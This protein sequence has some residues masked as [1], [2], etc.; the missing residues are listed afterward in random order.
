MAEIGRSAEEK[1]EAWH[2]P[3]ERGGRVLGAR[4]SDRVIDSDLTSDAKITNIR[5]MRTTVDIED[6]ILDEVKRNAAAEGLSLG[7]AVSR[8]LAEALSSH[9]GTD[10]RTSPFKWHTAAM[11]ARVDLADKEAL[12]SALD[13]GRQP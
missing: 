2:A 12:Y 6:P 1:C 3:S 8:L 5:C 13:E 4:Q 10:T 7:K 9:R 11:G